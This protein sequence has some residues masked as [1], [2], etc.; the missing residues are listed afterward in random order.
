MRKA[1]DPRFF[2]FFVGK[3]RLRAAVRRGDVCGV[4]GGRDGFAARSET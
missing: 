2:R 3:S 1:A 4:G